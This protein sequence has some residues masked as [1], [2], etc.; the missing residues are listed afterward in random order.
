MLDNL[1]LEKKTI[2]LTHKKK[3]LL[4]FVQAHVLTNRRRREKKNVEIIYLNISLLGRTY[5]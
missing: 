3:L 4:I 1:H 5:L 2:F